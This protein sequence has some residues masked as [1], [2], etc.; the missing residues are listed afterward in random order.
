MAR[1]MEMARASSGIAWKEACHFLGGGFFCVSLRIFSSSFSKLARKSLVNAA[2]CSAITDACLLAGS[3]TLV[4]P[5]RSDAGLCGPVCSGCACLTAHAL[6]C[7]LSAEMLMTCD[8]VAVGAPL[9]SA[10]KRR[11]AQFSA[12]LGIC[13]LRLGHATQCTWKGHK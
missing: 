10:P 9:R 4:A 2:A 1:R 7:T 6:K 3:A 13:N 5:A 12:S 8:A 11:R